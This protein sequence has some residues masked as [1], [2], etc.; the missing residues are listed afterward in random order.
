MLEAN[1]QL[2]RKLET[3]EKSVA[4]MDADTKRQF[5]KLRAVVFSLASPPAKK[6]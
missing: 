5:K 1:A 2:A 3:L 6:Q 4:V